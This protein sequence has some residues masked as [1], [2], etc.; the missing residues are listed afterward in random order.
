LLTTAASTQQAPDSTASRD[1]VLHADLSSRTLAPGTPLFAGLQLRNVSDHEV[2]IAVIDSSAATSHPNSGFQ[3]EVVTL[4]GERVPMSKWGRDSAREPQR[5]AFITLLPGDAQ[6]AV[7]DV[8]RAFELTKPGDYVLRVSS[9]GAHAVP[10][11]FSLVDG[12][13]PDARHAAVPDPQSD[14]AKAV[15]AAW[16]ATAPLQVT[17][18]VGKVITRRN[19]PLKLDL[20]LTNW[21]GQP[22]RFGYRNW[23]RLEVVLPDGR[24]IE[25]FG[26]R[27]DRD[28]NQFIALNT[29]APGQRATFT[30]VVQDRFMFPAPGDY[31]LRFWFPRARA[32][33]ELPVTVT[34][35]IA[36]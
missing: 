11:I 4:D 15:Y 1:L 5:P 13:R 29:I 14:A 30:T 34:D 31:A 17:G 32:A 16:L 23:V 36:H 21:S 9:Q 3:L 8:A 10:L 18:P 26:E 25:T 6:M 27:G 7:L 28:W 20:T 19:A 35:D 33:Y 22:V 24:T 12:A 2:Q